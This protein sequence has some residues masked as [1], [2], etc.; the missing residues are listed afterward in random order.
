MEKVGNSYLPSFWE[1]IKVALLLQFWLKLARDMLSRKFKWLH[2]VAFPEHYK[3][4]TNAPILCTKWLQ[5]EIA[6]NDFQEMS[7]LQC[8][9]WKP[10][11]VAQ[12]M[13]WKFVSNKSFFF[14]KNIFFSYQ[15]FSKCYLREN[16]HWSQPWTFSHI[17][18]Y[19]KLFTFTWHDVSPCVACSPEKPSLITV[20]AFQVFIFVLFP[21]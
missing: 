18:F 5:N 8:L 6:F 14:K 10:V 3:F 9:Q 17:H 11:E 7:Q 21:S 1:Q 15:N 16:V 20:N 4:Q 19:N 13:H 12:C 2:D